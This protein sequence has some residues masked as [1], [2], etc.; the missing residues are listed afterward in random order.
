[1]SPSSTS[2]SATR[3]GRVPGGAGAMV[4]SV[5]A[6]RA[7]AGTNSR[8][9][10]NTG[11]NAGSTASSWA[12]LPAG[13]L[14]QMPAT[15]RT[16]VVGGRRPLTTMPAIAPPATRATAPIA[17]DISLEFLSPEILIRPGSG[18][19]SAAFVSVP[20]ATVDEHHRPVLREHKVGGAGQLPHMK[21]ISKPSGEKKRAKCS[22]RPS[23]LSSDAR[24]HAAALWS[25]RDAHGF[26][27]IPLGC[28]QKQQPLT[29]ANKSGR[30]K[31][32][33]DAL[34]RSLA[35]G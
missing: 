30:T 27:G 10:P 20:E 13:N 6:G 4:S 23:V 2:G 1:M 8:T 14:G 7:P 18:C 9:L 26:G 29:A 5:A 22:F 12:G 21:S 33:P 35:W 15:Q 24:H 32:V 31:A 11:P 28:L 25:G 17:I 3:G 19:V 34:F 16:W